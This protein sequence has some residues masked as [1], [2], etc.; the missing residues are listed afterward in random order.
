[1]KYIYTKIDKSQ[2][3]AGVR[4]DT[5]RRNQGQI[6]EVSY[7]TFGRYEAGAGDPYKRCIDHSEGGLAT[8]SYYRR[9]ETRAYTF[10]IFDD[11]PDTSSGTA[12]PT[13][14]RVALEADSDTDALAAVREAMAA[15][16][17]GLRPADGYEAGYLL[18]A[19]VWDSDG[20]D[21]GRVT[22]EL[23]ADDIPSPGGKP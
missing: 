21:V 2:I 19:L 18:Y 17:T 15:N 22:Y 11:N 6:V 7:G 3:P 14:T 23:T 4:F 10:T 13:H 9:I 8:A 5:P 16:A 1:M 20:V 12:W